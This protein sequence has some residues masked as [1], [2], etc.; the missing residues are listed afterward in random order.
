M[1]FKKKILF[2]FKMCLICVF[3]FH[4]CH[5]GTVLCFFGYGVLWLHKATGWWV[6]FIQELKFLH[7]LLW[8]WLFWHYCLVGS[9]VFLCIITYPFEMDCLEQ[10]ANELVSSRVFFFFFLHTCLS[11]WLLLDYSFGFVFSMHTFWVWCGK[12]AIGGIKCSYRVICSHV[13][14]AIGPRKGLLS[15]RI[16]HIWKSSYRNAAI[17]YSC[18]FRVYSCIYQTRL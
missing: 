18:V 11:I 4:Y 8:I 2:F 6:S 12:P 13:F 9:V 1:F 5:V 10:L 7:I 3:G 14:A 15:H 17:A 16:G